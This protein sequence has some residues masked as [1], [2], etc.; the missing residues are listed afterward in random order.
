MINKHK[1]MKQPDLIDSLLFKGSE[2]IFPW[3]SLMLLFFYIRFSIPGIQPNGWSLHSDLWY[4]AGVGSFFFFALWG[5]QKKIWT[6]RFVVIGTI[7]VLLSF[8]LLPSIYNTPWSVAPIFIGYYF[9]GLGLIRFYVNCRAKRCAWPWILPLIQILGYHLTHSSAWVILASTVMIILLAIREL[10]C[11]NML[12]I[13]YI[14][15]LAA[16]YMIMTWIHDPC[17]PILTLRDIQHSEWKEGTLGKSLIV[18][19][20]GKYVVVDGVSWGKNALDKSF[21][22]WSNFQDR[23]GLVGFKDKEE[24][25]RMTP[26]MKKN[27]S[28]LQYPLAVT[29]SCV[30]FSAN[31]G[32][33]KQIKNI[34]GDRVDSLTAQTYFAFLDFFDRADSA[35]KV[36]L[37]VNYEMLHKEFLARSTDST[38]YCQ[39]NEKPEKL[40]RDYTRNLSL[41]LLNAMSLDLINNRDYKSASSLFTYQFLLTLYETPVFEHVTTSLSF[42]SKVEIGGIHKSTDFSFPVSDL[43]R[44]DTFEPWTK[45]FQMNCIWA[46]GYRKDHIDKGGALMKGLSSEVLENIKMDVLDTLN[47]QIILSQVEEV[48]NLWNGSKYTRNLLDFAKAQQAFL[49]DCIYR[50]YL[51]DYQFFFINR[52]DWINLLFP[53]SWETIQVYEGLMKFFD[54]RFEN[55]IMEFKEPLSQ[56]DT[57]KKQMEKM[58]FLQKE[59]LRKRENL[60]K[61]MKDSGFSEEILDLLLGD[62]NKNKDK[63]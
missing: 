51:T 33:I 57:L 56:M 7:L 4:L 58:V 39:N 36:S 14:S 59:V 32:T 2:I 37:Q 26:F 53:F 12:R 3:I 40:L 31:T 8:I 60:I 62:L 49:H 38:A 25:G 28:T 45:I 10:L 61:M 22:C 15:A 41:G 30:Y 43:N 50:N 16:F 47:S 27:L 54:A 6:K 5:Y 1:I 13:L 21:D 35:S 24:W 42:N 48:F 19:Q 23:L 18:E 34:K 9:A 29:D 20:E 46:L 17:N 11:G 63:L 55:N 52:Y 44:K